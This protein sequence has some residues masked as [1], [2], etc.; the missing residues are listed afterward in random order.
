MLFRSFSVGG[1]Q[2]ISDSV[3]VFESRSCFNSAF[4]FDCQ[5]CENCFGATNLRHKKF[6]WFNEQ[7]TEGE[8]KK[9][10]A[11]VDLSDRYQAEKYQQEFLNLVKNK[12]LWPSVH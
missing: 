1:S 8:Y 12:A 3:F 2:H 10:R 7:L 11:A 4:L 9:R 6:L 5:E